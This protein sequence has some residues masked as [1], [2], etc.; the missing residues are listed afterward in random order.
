LTTSIFGS[1]VL[2]TEDPRFLG[3]QARYVENIL[4]EGALRG[5]FVRS[6]M[7][8][9]RLLGVDGTA[10]QAMPGVAAVLVAADLALAPQPPSGSVRG[11]FSRPVLADGVVRYVGESVGLVLAETAAQAMDAVEAMRVEYDP[12]PVVVDPAAALAADAPLLFP[13]ARTNLA[14]EFLADWDRD[15]LS[16]SDVVVRARFVNQ[17]LAPV[18]MEANAVLAVPDAGGG[19]VVWVSTQI[20]FDVRN[21]VAEWLGLP[22]DKV[23]VV[24]P[25]VGG[26][27]GSKLSV[28]PEYLVCAAAAVRTGRPV[29]WM[30]TRS[31]SMVSLTHGRGQIHDVE[32]GARNDGTLVG[33]RVD[34]LADMGAY[35]MATYLPPTTRVML[36]GV[37][38]IP[39]IAC[40][41]RSV[42]TNT[43]PV[44]PYRGA[45]RPEATAL[46]E[47][48]MDLLA[49][50]L[51]LDPAEVRRRNLIPRDAF[52]H[53]TAVGTTYDVG[54]YER[55]L[56]EALR[57]IDYA[58]LRR[59][60]AARRARGD[61]VQLGIGLSTY[62]EITGFAPEL[63]SVEV[64]PDGTATVRTGISPHGQGHETSLAQVAS[65]VLGMEIDDVRVFH[66]DTALVPSG[67]GTYGSRSLQI[68]G[69]AV[70][71]ASQAVLDKARRL[72]AHLLEVP[73]ADVVRHEDGRL[74][75]AGVP[76]RSLTWAQLALA[77]AGPNLPEGLGPGLAATVKFKQRESTFPFG[78]HV[79]VVEVDVETGEALAI[80]HVAVDDC[81]RILNPLLVD[82][83]VHGGLAQGIA[84]ALYEEVVYDESGT[85]V[86]SNLTS[87]LVPS[88][89]EMPAFAIAHTETPTPLNPLGAKGIGE[90][91]TIG[92]T[93]AVQNAVLDAIAYLG[94]RHL[95][96]PLSPERVWRAIRDAR[97]AEV[98]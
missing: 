84:Q 26:G 4:A 47:R 51:G 7:A 42:V 71:E 55:S 45:G 95:D 25:D 66:S 38:R 91:A 79:S 48:V 24:A 40:R 46:L 81:G 22:R 90:S 56:D 76:D 20:P 36:A 29:R 69:S 94:V 14:D 92:S 34:I 52:P 6:I 96:M 64:A 19:L 72:A 18:P 80:R 53:Q 98:P 27:F 67:E 58:E 37:Y 83:Q 30:E 12:L 61:R 70:W 65:G 50:E 57:I 87:Y 82:G 85:P 28:Y 5:A 33:L 15:V 75:V 77:A 8:H 62:V 89:T 63:G 68:G 78:C 13:N 73:E 10:A 86:T 97:S 59:D 44:G 93:P 1:S 2:R 39:R 60:Q 3:G 74:G 88:A 9:G 35:P 32:L 23:R 41:G 54:D 11:P 17:R 49:G 16:G 21:D 43:T 31:E